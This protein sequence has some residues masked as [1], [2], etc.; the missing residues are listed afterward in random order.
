MMRRGGLRAICDRVLHVE[1]DVFAPY[2]KPDRIRALWKD[3]M[4]GKFDNAFALWPILT[5][6]IWKAGLAAA[7]NDRSSV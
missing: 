6:G 3:H 5:L 7:N 2:L 4:E 1:A